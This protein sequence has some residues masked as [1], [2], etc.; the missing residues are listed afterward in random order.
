MDLADQRTD[1]DHHRGD[2]DRVRQ[3]LVQ[4]PDRQ[5]ADTLRGDW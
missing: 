5:S 4:E 2:R 1:T 3:E